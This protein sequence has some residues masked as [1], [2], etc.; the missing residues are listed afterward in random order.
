MLDTRLFNEVT[1]TYNGHQQS[2]I[3]TQAKDDPIS[4]LMK[5]LVKSVAPPSL[6]ILLQCF[7]SLEGWEDFMEL[8]NEYTPE[9]RDEILREN[10]QG[11]QMEIFMNT[12]EAKYFQLQ[13]DWVTQN[14]QDWVTQNFEEDNEVGYSVLTENVPVD[15]LGWDYDK[16]DE[17]PSTSDISTQLWCYLL[18]NP[19][20]E[21]DERVALADACQN[22][23]PRA[24]LSRV[25]AK[26]FPFDKL[27]DMLDGTKYSFIAKFGDWLSANTGNYF[28]DTDEESYW[29]GYKPTW[30]RPTIEE[31]TE[32][33]K[34]INRFFDERNKFQDWF[35]KDTV[36]HFQELLNFMLKKYNKKR[37]EKHDVTPDTNGRTLAET[38]TTDN[39]EEDLEEI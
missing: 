38:L 10:D 30:D 12:F 28:L 20:D 29:Q 37:K 36:K 22:V 19:S 26:G 24:I 18:P 17:L 32:N 7:S 11:K 8:V 21:N 9:K 1:N 27:H 25:P 3:E 39:R 16:Y 13:Q 33:G 31:L 34:E 23:V 35:E 14:F 2:T 6:S 5:L 15:V 4:I